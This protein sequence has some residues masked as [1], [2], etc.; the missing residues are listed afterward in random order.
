LKVVKMENTKTKKIIPCLDIKDGKVVKG[1]KFEG[2]K[3]ISSPI[4]LATKYNSSGADEL[5]FYDIMASIE[6]RGVFTELLKQVLDNIT[7][8]LTVG[9][10]INTVDDFGRMLDLGV[11]KISIN[12]GVI[13]NPDLISEASKKY[14][15][16]RV[17]FAADIK[18]VNGEY[19]VFAKGG[20][21][22]TGIEAIEW[23]KN[24]ANNGAGEIVANS[25]DTDG[26]KTGYDLPL[27]KAICNVVNIPVTASGGA[28]TPEDFITLF[29]EIP[30]IG[31]A[32]AASV[33]HYDEIKIPD[34]KQ[35]LHKSG[36]N[37]K[38]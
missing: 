14:G 22:N 12:S 13:K 34:L 28:G 9:G 29:T 5:V 19:R 16:D 4:E 25:I 21:E 8:P 38:L 31:A 3:E 23:L 15:S 27:L 10:G 24:G 7:I 20:R 18:F 17:V 2:V 37:V 30:T 1:V 35:Q 11:S 26:I 6:G 36:I 32:L 33:F